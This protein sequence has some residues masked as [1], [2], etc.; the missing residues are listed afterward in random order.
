MKADREVVREATPKQRKKSW[1]SRRESKNNTAAS[2]PAS[3][4]PS[5][6]SK[7]P[8]SPRSSNEKAPAIPDEDDL[9][10]RLEFTQHSPISSSS[11]T[12]SQPLSPRASSGSPS[13]SDPDEAGF[14]LAAIHDV[15]AKSG[16]KAQA[17]ADVLHAPLAK[18]PHAAM[19]LASAHEP[20]GRAESAPLP[21]PTEDVTD[22]VSASSSQYRPHLQSTRTRVTSTPYFGGSE[23]FETGSFDEDA[24]EISQGRG[25]ATPPPSGAETLDVDRD[26]SRSF[27][28][29]V[30]LD[31]GALA[32]NRTFEAY[33]SWDRRDPGISS[34]GYGSSLGSSGWSSGAAS[35]A[36]AKL[37]EASL[38]F[39]GPGGGVWGASTISNASVPSLSFAP[40]SSAPS[41]LPADILNPFAISSTN[42]APS[43]PNGSSDNWAPPP[44]TKKSATTGGSGMSS[45]N[46]SLR[47]KRAASNVNLSANPWG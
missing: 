27:A 6:L 28:Q 12:Q 37:D 45:A 40:T 1:F 4:P 22:A 24:R 47:G 44:L 41:E 32:A 38:S 14:D 43:E 16:G 7:G 15:I 31:S 8:T 10:E 2:R 20:S 39:G 19:S 35:S 3:R 5:A 30:S 25:F 46:G 11:E 34:M 42:L 33:P 13:P 29:S 21:M 9:P 23:E 26:L 18:S 36:K 17:D